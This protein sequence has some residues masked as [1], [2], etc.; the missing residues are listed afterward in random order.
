MKHKKKT[1]RYGAGGSSNPLRD[2][3]NI[4]F[5]RKGVAVGSYLEGGTIVYGDDDKKKKSK[6]KSKNKKV[7]MPG[8][9]SNVNLDKAGKKFSSYW[10][11]FK[12][13]MKTPII[14]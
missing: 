9:I 5:A 6:N 3:N 2:L 1:K 11:Q 8:T 13:I 12:D 7:P 10:K 14:K 4:Q